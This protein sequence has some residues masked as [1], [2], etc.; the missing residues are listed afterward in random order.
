MSAGGIAGVL[1]RELTVH[2]DGR[3]HLSEYF[4][5]DWETGIEPLQW[6]VLDCL[7]GSLRGVHLHLAHVDYK[8]TLVGRQLLALVDLRL[9][10]PTEGRIE[11]HDVRG[12]ELVG[13]TIPPGVGHG[14]YSYDHSTSV[15]AASLLYDGDDDFECLWSDPELGIEWPSAPTL[16]SERDR[17]A[18]TLGELRERLGERLRIPA[19]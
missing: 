5:V 1:R 9:G 4:R 16:L 13:I 14:V 18:P 6:H 12:D 11:L 15:V 3:G 19:S 10:S 17:T 8:V 2:R 7:P